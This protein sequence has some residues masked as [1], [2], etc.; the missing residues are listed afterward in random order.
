MSL[1]DTRWFRIYLLGVVGAALIAV[2]ITVMVGLSRRPRIEPAPMPQRPPAVT[3]KL[4]DFLIDDPVP[5]D[6]PDW[7]LT[8]PPRQKWE[9][10]EVME[11]WVDPVE[12]GIEQLGGENDRMVADFFDAVP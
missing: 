9:R 3:L 12:M 8:R 6:E 10:E 1:F 11:F 2:V 5:L 4:S 7:Q